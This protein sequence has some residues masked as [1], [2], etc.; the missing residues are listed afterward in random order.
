MSP[1]PGSIALSKQAQADG[2]RVKRKLLKKAAEDK[3]ISETYAHV[4]HRDG[5]DCRVCLR[6]I[7]GRG[8]LMN[9]A[10]HHHLIYRSRIGVS[11]GRHHPRNVCRICPVCDAEIHVEYTLRIEGD[12]EARAAESGKLCGIKVERYT[13]AGWRVVKFC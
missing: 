5:D 13:E 6:H 3:E 12:A 8:G 1:G 9:K 4:D 11:Q 10:I 2:G 7:S